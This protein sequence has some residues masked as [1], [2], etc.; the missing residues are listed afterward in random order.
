MW[1]AI[2]AVLLVFAFLDTAD[3]RPRAWCGWWMGQHLGNPDRALWRARNWA[4]VGS[5][6]DGPGV[7]V[8]VVWRHHVGI[9][10]GRANDGEWLVTSGNDGGRV[11]ERPRSLATVIAMRRP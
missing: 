11:R 8:V 9:I 3:A 7:G 4:R 6:A 1:R 5:P 2:L 10:T